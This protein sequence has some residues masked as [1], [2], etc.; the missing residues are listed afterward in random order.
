MVARYYYLFKPFIS[1]RVRF[2]IRRFLVA[3]QLNRFR[4]IWPI[5]PGASIHPPWFNGW[6]EKKKFAFIVTHD[7]EQGYGLTTGLPK[8]LAIDKAFSIRS[9]VGLVPERYRVDAATLDSFH[10]RGIEIYVHDLYHDGKLFSN[11][12]TFH[13][14][15]SQINNYL[16]QWK[17]D[18]FRAG[19]MHHNLDWIGELK[20]KYDM[21]TFDTDPFEPMPDGAGTIFPFV[22]KSSLTNRSYVE[23]PY[24]L[25]Q[26]LTTLLL[27]PRQSIDIWI[28]KLNWIAERNGMVSVNVHPDYMAFDAHELSFNKYPAVEYEKLLTYVRDRFGDAFWNPLPSELSDFVHQSYQKIMPGMPKT[29]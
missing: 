14:R 6:P 8:L 26:D 3:S 22:A 21:S 23:I 27:H 28:E 5:D 13:K 11:Y 9:S 25:P 20:I 15:A 4:K 19:A 24:T 2:C 16:Q 18:G 29:N 10:K 12:Q 17:V 7:I 1:C